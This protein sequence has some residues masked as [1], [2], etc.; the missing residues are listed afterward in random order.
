V[1]DLLPQLAA[2]LLLAGGAASL[3]LAKLLGKPGSRPSRLGP[4][5]ALGGSAAV[6]A[7][8]SAPPPAWLA[9]GLVA[10][11]WLGSRVLLSPLV[12]AACAVALAALRRP[13]VQGAVLL[14]LAP[15]FGL[16]WVGTLPIALP[17]DAPEDPR[18]AKLSHVVKVRPVEGLEFY[19]DRGR[20]I[21]AYE[22]SPGELAGEDLHDLEAVMLRRGE[23]GAKVIR[24]AGPDPASNCH[25]WTFTGGRCWIRT[26]EAETILR[27]NGYRVVS[28]P[29]AGD[30]VAYRQDDGTLAHSGA[31]AAVLE[32]GTVLVESKWGWAGRYVHPVEAQQYAQRWEFLH[33]DREGHWLCGTPGSESGKRTVAE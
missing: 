11:L 21:R 24:V 29:R 7:W 33:S 5:L 20:R 8:W 15:L 9:L 6:L 2:A 1:N 23:L 16:A 25:G 22:P 3:G 17:D 31:V 19:T 14:A 13:R 10:A 27:D 4:A 12:A 32:D 26:A 28:A 30:V 18:A